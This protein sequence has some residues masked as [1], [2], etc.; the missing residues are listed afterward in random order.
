M[1]LFS[2]KM[3]IFKFERDLSNENLEYV[4]AYLFSVEMLVD[5]FKILLDL[6]NSG[7]VSQS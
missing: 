7:S 4:N 3:Y 5:Y 6:F 2:F 1:G